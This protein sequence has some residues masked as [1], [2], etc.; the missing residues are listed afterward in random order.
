MVHVKLV[1]NV[2]VEIIQLHTP[3]RQVE[4][5]KNMSR[6]DITKRSNA[7]LE[8]SQNSFK[9]VFRPFVIRLRETPIPQNLKKQN[10]Q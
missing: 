10:M 4:L 8:V 7:C 6:D 2:L 9:K 3:S 5:L 1:V